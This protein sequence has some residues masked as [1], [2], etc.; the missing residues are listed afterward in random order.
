M[1]I[2]VTRVWGCARLELLRVCVGDCSLELDHSLGWDKGAFVSEG[3]LGGSSGRQTSSST[4]RGFLSFGTTL[5]LL[6]SATRA[7]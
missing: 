5:V 4:R 3:S 6:R 2:A 7:V 1:R